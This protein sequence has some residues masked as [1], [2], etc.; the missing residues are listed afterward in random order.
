VF[1]L[2]KPANGMPPA[3]ADAD[4]HSDTERLAV[5]LE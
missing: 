3:P 1:E 5:S 2:D 4:V